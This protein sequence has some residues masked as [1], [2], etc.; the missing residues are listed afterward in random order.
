MEGLTKAITDRIVEAI[1]REARTKF[2][3][4]N[5]GD[6][7]Y[8]QEEDVVG[9]L[10]TLSEHLRGKVVYCPCD[11]PNTSYFYKTLHDNFG[12]W[13]LR[14]LYTTWMPNMSCYYDG[15][16]EVRG[17][18]KSGRFQDTD[19]FFTKCDVVITN[20]PFS[21]AQ[22]TEM[23]NMIHRHGKEYIMI[24][25]R[26]L[27]MLQSVFN[28]VR[29]GS[30]RTLDRRIDTFD[31]PE[32]KKAGAP[33]AVYTSFDTKTPFFK[34]G[35]KYDPNIHRKF[36]NLDAIDCG[37]N[38]NMIPD[39]YYGNIAVSA[40]GGGFLRKLNNDQFEIVSGIIRP[41]MD[42]KPKKRMLIRRKR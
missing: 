30:M 13:G 42:G 29:N 9:I 21:N 31:T 38:F 7:Y 35:V 19:E 11:N 8:T 2:A 36:D 37:D 18:I 15:K 25:D 6:E 26:A 14:G 41:K 39:D 20:P 24:A 16:N 28:Y 32:G 17:R 1:L 10:T 3:H 23:I 4:H 33:A 12:K 40:N 22:P 5:G 27:T 34:T